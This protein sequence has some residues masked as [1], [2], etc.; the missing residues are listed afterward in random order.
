MTDGVVLSLS[1]RST[2]TSASS[3]STSLSTDDPGGGSDLLPPS[4]GSTSDTMDNKDNLGGAS[5]NDDPRF[6]GNSST[7]KMGKSNTKKNDKKTAICPSC[8]LS[9]WVLDARSIAHCQFNSVC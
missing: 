7:S 4:V 1:G 3:G 2:E 6:R 8:P 9:S 5:T